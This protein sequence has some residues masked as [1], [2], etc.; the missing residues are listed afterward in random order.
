[1]SFAIAGGAYLR[2]K[3]GAMLLASKHFCR[4]AGVVA[5]REGGPRSPDEQTQTSSLPKELRTSSISPRVSSS[6][7]TLKGYSITFVFGNSFAMVSMSS[8]YLV[9]KPVSLS[10]ACRRQ[11]KFDLGLLNR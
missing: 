2:A 11:I 5:S 8:L 7:A 10:H 4:S 3:N 6:L 1:M 9:P